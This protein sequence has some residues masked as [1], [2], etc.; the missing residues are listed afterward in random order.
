[1][2]GKNTHKITLFLLLSIAII[3]F[4]I[5]ACNSKILSGKQ[6]ET[7]ITTVQTSPLSL[8]QKPVGTKTVSHTLGQTEIP[9][10]P[11]RIVVLDANNTFLLESLLALGIKPVGLTRCSNCINLDPFS[12]VVGDL[13]SVGTHQQPSLEKILRLKPDLILGYEWQKAFYP[14]L[15]KIAPTVMIDL[16]TGGNDFKRNFKHLAEILGKSDQVEGIVAE[17]NERIQKF[18]QR[19]GE[20]LK[21]K[22][23]CLLSFWDSTVHV[24]GPDLLFY[25]PVMREAGIK[26]IPAYQNLKD[27]Y[28]RLNIET[29]PDWDADFLFISFYYKKEFENLKSLSFFKQPIWSTLKAVRNKQ[30]YITTWTGGGPI[31]ANRLIDELYEYFSSKF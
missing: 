14:L 15:S 11:Q 22:T 18:R 6:G 8:E 20:K 13:P 7:K 30:V 16:Y 31:M 26:F 28:L 23:V 12:E 4:T 17:Y 29:V 21:N 27:D 25:G 24:Y 1:M 3:A 19:F 2:K 5:T 9:L 10:H